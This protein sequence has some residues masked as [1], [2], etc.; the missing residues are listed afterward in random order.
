MDCYFRWEQT[1]A[2]VVVVVVVF[3]FVVYDL[4]AEKNTLRLDHVL[5]SYVSLN[6]NFVDRMPMLSCALMLK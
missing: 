4:K 1:H 3:V 5:P 6:T 2:I